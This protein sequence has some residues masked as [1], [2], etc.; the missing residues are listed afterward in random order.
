MCQKICQYGFVDHPISEFAMEAHRYC[1]LIEDGSFPNW[2]EFAQACLT[3]LMRLNQAALLLPEVESKGVK[4][5]ER[6]E[7]ERWN[8]IRES[9]AARLAQD[10]YWE[11]FN[12]L[13]REE[14]R[15]LLGSLSDDLAGIWHDLSCGLAVTGSEKTSLARDI[16]WHWRFSFETHWEKH[17]V[18]AIGALHALSFGNLAD[19]SGPSSIAWASG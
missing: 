6:I 8:A 16:V 18:D 14:P 5:L 13:E 7:H 2:W 12:P 11:I 17:A 10:Y 1:L 19:G 15:P 4:L 9:I 3:Q